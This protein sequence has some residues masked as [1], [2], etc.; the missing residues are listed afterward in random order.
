MNYCIDNEAL[1]DLEQIVSVNLQLM[2]WRYLSA[3]A[4]PAIPDRWRIRRK[5]KIA[6]VNKVNSDKIAAAAAA[7]VPGVLRFWQTVA[8]A[9]LV[10]AEMVVSV[11]PFAA[12][13][14]AAAGDEAAVDAAASNGS[15]FVTAAGDAA[16]VGSGSSDSAGGTAASAAAEP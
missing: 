4:A 16:A 11:A 13:A 10:S 5:E 6:M 9:L 1:W 12:A 2:K 3:T 8:V 15:D 7:A 14:A